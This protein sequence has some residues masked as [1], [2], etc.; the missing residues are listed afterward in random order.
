MAEPATSTA[1]IAV[2]AIKLWSLIASV[3]GSAIP[4]LALSDKKKITLRSAAVSAAV[5][6][7]FAIFLGPWL[8]QKLDFTTPESLSALSW[9]LGGTGVY[10]V[11]AVITWLDEKGVGAIDRV[12]D[13][14]IDTLPG[15]EEHHDIEINVDL[16]EKSEDATSHEAYKGK[17]DH[18]K[19]D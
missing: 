12:V 11:R 10:I 19:P 5:G 18:Y 7:S 14:L 6:S 17:A 2:A 15:E 9:V 8:A 13:R 16:S 1:A 4:L 3:A